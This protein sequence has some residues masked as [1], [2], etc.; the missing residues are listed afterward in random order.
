MV[1]NLVNLLF[2]IVL[3]AEPVNDEFGQRQNKPRRQVKL[4]ID[5]H[6]CGYFLSTQAWFATSAYFFLGYLLYSYSTEVA[7][8]PL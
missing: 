6:F 8:L 4:Q 2:G 5:V 3:S 1:A 7:V